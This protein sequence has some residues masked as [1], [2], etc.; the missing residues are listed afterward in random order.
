[1]ASPSGRLN[2]PVNPV[3]R[4]TQRGQLAAL[5]PLRT[6]A[7]LRWLTWIGI[8]SNLA[9]SWLGMTWA[10]TL[11]WWWIAAGW[12]LFVSAPGRIL[13]AAL[14]CRVILRHLRPGAYP[15]GGR[16]H[17]RVWLA[18]RLADELGAANLAGAT[19]M[20]WYARLLGA[21]VGRHVD[22]H[23]IP[24]VTGMLRLGDGASIE[25]EVDLCGHWQDGATFHVGP[26]DIGASA[27]VGA[28]T[29][30]GPGTVIGDG[31]EIAA[32][33]A[34]FGAVPAGQSWSG[35]PAQHVGA[36][37]VP[38]PRRSAAHTVPPGSSPTRRCRWSSPRCR[39]SP[40]GS[41]W[42]CW[43]HPWVRRADWPRRSGSPLPGYRWPPWP[44]GPASLSA[45]S[46]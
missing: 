27:R 31:A 18:E 12:L 19:G 30:L 38:G 39:C 6:I 15:R 9:S 22:L 4:K 21:S 25:P 17:L 32:G 8:G 5:I 46:C 44:G 34:V 33:S 7:A 36:A 3:P 40:W 28:R 45:C 35:A 43:R 1:M 2:A 42:P 23:A 14:G 37:R 16:V 24:P 20:R 41:G 29:T 13:L 10:P 26:I 11:S